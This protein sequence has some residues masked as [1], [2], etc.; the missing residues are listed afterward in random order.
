MTSTTNNNDDERYQETTVANISILD[1]L[2]TAYYNPRSPQEYNQVQK[3]II[4]YYITETGIGSS[5]PLLSSSSSFWKFIYSPDTLPYHVAHLKATDNCYTQCFL[6]ATINGCINEH[7]SLISMELRYEIAQFLCEWI[8]T[9]GHYRNYPYLFDTPTTS[10]ETTTNVNNQTTQTNLHTPFFRNRTQLVKERRAEIQARRVATSVTTRTLARIIRLSLGDDLNYS[11]LLLELLE[12]II[13]Y[14]LTFDNPTDNENTN[15]SV[16]NSSNN[17]SNVNTQE[18]MTCLA[19]FTIIVREMGSSSTL[20][21][22]YLSSRD[23]TIN[24]TVFKYLII[25]KLL[26]STIS[27]VQ[28][29]YRVLYDCFQYFVEEYERTA[30]VVNVNSS[31]SSSSSSANLETQVLPE[32]YNCLELLHISTD[33]ALAIVDYEDNH[34]HE[35]LQ[36]QRIDTGVVSGDND[37]NDNDDDNEE[38]YGNGL[39]FSVTVTERMFGQDYN[40]VNIPLSWDCF[41]EPLNVIGTY[42][43]LIR[44]VI[45]FIYH[46]IGTDIAGT[47]DEPFIASSSS[48]SSKFSSFSQRSATNRRPNN[49]LLP[50]LTAFYSVGSKVLQFLSVLSLVVS[51]EWTEDEK[52][53]RSHFLLGQ[54]TYVLAFAIHSRNVLLPL[55]SSTFGTNGKKNHTQSL[56]S[57]LD[58]HC[59]IHEICRLVGHAKQGFRFSHV[60]LYETHLT[61]YLVLL[62]TFTWIILGYTDNSDTLT[63]NAS[64]MKEISSTSIDHILYTWVQLF[65]FVG[66]LNYRMRISRLFRSLLAPLREAIFTRFPPVSDIPVSEG[67]I[68]NFN[69]ADENDSDNDEDDGIGEISSVAAS[70]KVHSSIEETLYNPSMLLYIELLKYDLINTLEDLYIIMDKSLAYIS[71][72]A[73]PVPCNLADTVQ[74]H[75]Q[76]NREEKRLAWF[77]QFSTL[78]IMEIIENQSH[79]HERMHYAVGLLPL[80]SIETDGIDNYPVHSLHPSILSSYGPQIARTVLRLTA[81]EVCA[82]IDRS[83]IIPGSTMQNTSVYGYIDSWL[84]STG[85]SIFSAA[86]DASDGLGTDVA[87]ENQINENLAKKFKKFS[88]QSIRSSLVNKIAIEINRS[89]EEDPSVVATPIEGISSSSSIPSRGSLRS[90]GT[91]NYRNR[92][93]STENDVS[94]DVI[95]TLL[96]WT[97]PENVQTNEIIYEDTHFRRICGCL[98]TMMDPDLLNNAEYLR[99]RTEKNPYNPLFIIHDEV[100]RFLNVPW[101]LPKWQLPSSDSSGSLSRISGDTVLRELINDDQYSIDEPLTIL[102]TLLFRIILSIHHIDLPFMDPHDSFTT[103]TNTASS[104]SRFGTINR[105]KSV[106]N[107]SGTSNEKMVGNMSTAEGTDPLQEEIN[108]LSIRLFQTVSLGTT[109]SSSNS[110][111]YPYLNPNPVVSASSSSTFVNRPTLPRFSLGRQDT[112]GENWGIRPTRQA[113]PNSSSSSSLSPWTNGRRKLELAILYFIRNFY[114]IYCTHRN[115]SDDWIQA[116]KNLQR[117]KEN[118]LPNVEG[119]RYTTPSSISLVSSSSTLRQQAMEDAESMNAGLSTSSALMIETLEKRLQEESTKNILVQLLLIMNL[120]SPSQLLDILMLKVLDG[121]RQYCAVPVNILSFSLQIFHE[122]ALGSL[123]LQEYIN[124][125]VQRQSINIGKD[126]LSTETVQ[127]FLRYPESLLFSNL[128][129]VP[130]YSYRTLFYRTITRLLFLYRKSI[131]KPAA[132]LLTDSSIHRPLVDTGSNIASTASIAST[133]TKSE[134]EP[135]LYVYTEENSNDWFITFMEPFRNRFDRLTEILLPDSPLLC[136]EDGSVYSYR[137]DIANEAKDRDYTLSIRSTLPLQDIKNDLISILRD[138]RGILLAVQSPNEYRLVHEWLT[139]NR[140]HLL[141]CRR[142]PL[143]YHCIQDADIWIPLLRCL[144]EYATNTMTRIVF[145]PGNTSGYILFREIACCLNSCY[146]Y[147]YEY[148]TEIIVTR[149]KNIL[150]NTDTLVYVKLLRLCF[151]NANTLLHNKFANV[152]V[153]SAFQDISGAEV[154]YNTI[155]LYLCVPIPWIQKYPKLSNSM[156]MVVRILINNPLPMIMN[157]GSSM[158]DADTSS[159]SSEGNPPS[160]RA[161]TVIPY[162]YL[163]SLP[164]IY[165]APNSASTDF[166]KYLT[167][168]HPATIALLISLP[169]TL[170]LG[171]V[172]RIQNLLNLAVSRSESKEKVLFRSTYLPVALQGLEAI[173][174]VETSARYVL[175]NAPLPASNSNVS[176]S[177]MAFAHKLYRTPSGIRLSY[178][179]AVNICTNMD[180]HLTEDEYEIFIASISSLN[181]TDSSSASLSSTTSSSSSSSSVVVVMESVHSCIDDELLKLINPQEM[182]VPVRQGTGNIRRTIIG[183]ES[184]SSSSSIR[185]IFGVSFM[186]QLL[187]LAIQNTTTVVVDENNNNNIPTVTGTGSTTTPLKDDIGMNIYGFTLSQQITNYLGRIIL[188]NLINRPETIERAIDTIVTSTVNTVQTELLAITDEFIETYQSIDNPLTMKGKEDFLGAFRIW[189]YELHGKL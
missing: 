144:T 47:D 181:G 75:Q 35:T 61:Q 44:L 68:T 63:M 81:K 87:V 137:A 41:K 166:L 107:R 176:S 150:S 89:T 131:S 139:E 62:G 36:Q 78:L 28:Q 109:N 175:D 160:I 69:G 82:K 51:E 38:K 30:S 171:I 187:Y 52:E 72:Q 157:G 60:L 24:R 59:W 170:F 167:V 180:Q 118:S 73:S 94:I 57:V 114:T 42:Y 183:S 142:I 100:L 141:F 168:P 8:V 18:I 79:Q 161:S 50:V 172:Y 165:P 4:Q 113:F 31:S 145:P 54:S 159:S 185:G 153:M 136:T 128:R 46:T 40:S 179:E 156:C 133:I 1:G 169:S 15:T 121:V 134:P 83:E 85:K 9:Y 186:I 25:S 98:L 56:W 27:I 22:R 17:S 151:L 77:V 110:G 13:N 49:Q 132:P 93:R 143:L 11:S 29:Q 108:N 65:P 97:V 7:W 140:F 146:E 127:S 149:T 104:F 10:T 188:S 71:S 53:V 154:W 34:Q 152:G 19:M 48:S 105:N 99:N 88:L 122:Y 20:T 164:R 3:D 124:I 80:D 64:E 162:G 96:Q 155:R 174:T 26:S 43:A 32:F 101:I 138:L 111:T 23:R 45:A 86:N 178:S 163:N 106:S 112:E 184:S 33:L 173:L 120:S 91:L 21:H 84:L 66:V 67:N 116:M 5:T 123:V 6:A 37:N 147:L 95:R 58:E 129:L 177:P 135:K 117:V 182:G 90:V 55:S 130:N 74:T 92:D 119:N 189:C 16:P 76:C 126:I 158:N 103:T 115:E 39:P 102:I 2:C 70:N 14:T 12:K 148:Y 125:F